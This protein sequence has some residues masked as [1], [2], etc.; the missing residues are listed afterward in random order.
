MSLKLDYCKQIQAN[1]KGSGVGAAEPFLFIEF[2]VSSLIFE[3]W[4][5]PVSTF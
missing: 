4:G 5:R 1:R 3:N 2:V